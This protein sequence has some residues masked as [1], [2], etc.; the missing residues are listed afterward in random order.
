M[1]SQGEQWPASQKYLTVQYEWRYTASLPQRNHQLSMQSVSFHDSGVLSE[2][3]R[4][5]AATFPLLCLSLASRSHW[6]LRMYIPSHPCNLHGKKTPIKQL[7]MK[8]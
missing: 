1:K 6:F 8:Y 4:K 2:P 3:R 5:P 7:I